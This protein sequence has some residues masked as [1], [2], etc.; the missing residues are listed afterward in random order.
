[1]YMVLISCILAIGLSERER[2]GVTPDPFVAPYAL[3]CYSRRG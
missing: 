2:E 3:K 1:M